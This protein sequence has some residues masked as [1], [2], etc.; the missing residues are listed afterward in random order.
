MIIINKYQNT[1]DLL[2][3]NCAACLLHTITEKDEI[4]KILIQGNYKLRVNEMRDIHNI[5]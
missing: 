1:H 4:K 2:L 3:D 5:V